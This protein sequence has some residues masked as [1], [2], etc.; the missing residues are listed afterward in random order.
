MLFSP[1]QNTTQIAKYLLVSIL[2]YSSRH[3]LSGFEHFQRKLNQLNGLK[4][5]QSNLF[6]GWFSKSRKFTPLIGVIFTSV[7]QSWFHI[8]ESQR[9]VCSV[10]HLFETFTYSIKPK[11]NFSSKI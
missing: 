11:N 5:I 1:S 7:K 10:L 4:V 8:S 2:F 6:S 9:P 3:F